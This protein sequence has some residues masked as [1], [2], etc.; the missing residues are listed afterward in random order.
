MSERVDVEKKRDDGWLGREE[1]RG[2]KALG[3]GGGKIKKNKKCVCSEWGVV[4]SRFFS[5][6]LPRLFILKEGLQYLLMVMRSLPRL[7][8]SQNLPWL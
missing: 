6:P 5:K 2:E 4:M 3:V 7:F 1:R 8:Y